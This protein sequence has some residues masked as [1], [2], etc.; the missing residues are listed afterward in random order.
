[1]KLAEEYKTLSQKLAGLDPLA[2]AQSVRELKS[3]KLA[4]VQQWHASA[5]SHAEFKQQLDAAQFELLGPQQQ[6]ELR[7]AH[8][9]NQRMLRAEAHRKAKTAKV[10]S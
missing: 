7:V 4:I 10:K 1:M 2:D 8:E 6:K 9:Q 5:A 3:A